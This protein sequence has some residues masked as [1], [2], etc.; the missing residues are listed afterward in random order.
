MDP[1]IINT[2]FNNHRTR[3][4]SISLT[5]L[6]FGLRRRA[7]GLTKY[8][9]RNRQRVITF[10]VTIAMKRHDPRFVAALR[11]HLEAVYPLH[12]EVNG[13]RPM[14]K[15]G[16]DVIHM[17]FPTRSYFSEFLPFCL[18][19]IAQVMG[20]LGQSYL[21]ILTC[22]RFSYQFF[23]YQICNEESYIFQFLYVYFSCSKI[24]LVRNKLGIAVSSVFTVLSSILMS[25]GI[26]G[27][28]LNMNSKMCVVPYLVAFIS[29]ENILV[30][31]RDE[32]CSDKTWSFSISKIF[33]F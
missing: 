19:L 2:V 9:V 22:P 26:S 23:F 33:F 31:T 4:G 28:S 27:L 18:T 14:Q 30:I 10:A 8:P 7:T 16:G 12:H 20:N 21:N 24:E 15:P 5:D 13:S 11:A 1:N 6:V 29:L 25:L 3:Q 17:F 32:G